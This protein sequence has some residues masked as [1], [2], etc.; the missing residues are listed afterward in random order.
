M[1]PSHTVGTSDLGD[2][3]QNPTKPLPYTQCM[4]Y[5]PT[6]NLSFIHVGYIYSI[7]GAFGDALL[8]KRWCLK[9]HQHTPIQHPHHWWTHFAPV[10]YVIDPRRWSNFSHS[11]N[12]F[13]SGDN[14]NIGHKKTVWPSMISS[15]IFVRSGKSFG[16]N[17]LQCNHHKKNPFL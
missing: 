1:E 15:T 7:Y 12:W 13:L 16:L 4:E 11:A 10:W 17:E 6:I 9:S 8:Q 3:Q 14:L 5:S 2:V